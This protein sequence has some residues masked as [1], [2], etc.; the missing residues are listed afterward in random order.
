[1]PASRPDTS[2]CSS[3]DCTA[4]IC[5]VARISSNTVSVT[6]TATVGGTESVSIT[7]SATA[8][9][10]ASATVTG[11]NAPE[12]TYHSGVHAANSGRS[13]CGVELLPTNAIG[14]PEDF[15]NVVVVG[16][17]LDTNRALSSEKEAFLLRAA[18][19]AAL[20]A[21]GLTAKQIA[22]LDVADK[23]TRGLR[24]ARRQDAQ[25]GP[26]SV[27]AF[28]ETAEGIE[29]HYFFDGDVEYRIVERELGQKDIYI[30]VTVP[31]QMNLTPRLMMEGLV[32]RIYKDPVPKRMDV[33]KAYYNLGVAYIFKHMYEDAIQRIDEAIKFSGQ[34]PGYFG[35]LSLA[36]SLAGKKSDAR[37]VLE[38]LYELE[39]DRFVNSSGFIHLRLSRIG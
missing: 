39:K 10:V 12:L 2:G 13:S 20:A 35:F 33:E 9:T 19:K 34:S 37:R 11:P 31:D 8:S 27:V 7:T 5:P 3:I 23:L 22:M 1:M 38:Q 24:I 6:A 15:N 4:S 32:F 17:L 29:G 21:E 28:E 16:G 30:A 18:G 14:N 26:G 36:Y 25:R